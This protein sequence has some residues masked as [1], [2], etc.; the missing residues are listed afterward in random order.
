MCWECRC[1]RLTF[2]A[3]GWFA[4]AKVV[5]DDDSVS[6]DSLMSLYSKVIEMDS[7]SVEAQVALFAKA[8]LFED[9][10]RSRTR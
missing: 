2:A 7:A 3:I 1:G 4:A 10:L 8:N 9:T 6:T 5:Q